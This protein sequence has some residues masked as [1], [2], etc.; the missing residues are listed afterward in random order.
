MR[1]C[2]SLVDFDEWRA[3]AGAVA[4][5]PTMGFL[6]EGHLALV[7]RARETGAPVVAS[8][9]VNPLQFGPEE[10]FEVYPRDEAQDAKLLE[11]EGCDVLLLPT[12]ED[13]YPRGF[14]TRVSVGGALTERLCGATRPGHF[15][16][17]ATVV[18]RLFRIVRPR[19]AVFGAKD[20]Q[21]LL[22]VRRL[23]DDLRL[24]VEVIGH[25]IVREADGLALSSRNVH[26]SPSERDEALWIQRALMHAATLV[27]EGETRVS[28][29]EDA[30][31]GELAR[32]Q[33]VRPHYVNILGAD[34][35]EPLTCVDRPVVMA[36]AAFVGQARL[37]DNRVLCPP[38]W[39][40]RA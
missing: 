15:D 35:L 5:V 8:I 14:A 38:G 21:Q 36:I 7:R 22:V 33:G 25:E 19:W 27:D 39:G 32:A 16:G 3:D 23:V 30:L 6:H 13:F 31:R 26:L 9:F 11:G 40:D 12:V 24:D 20:Y 28:T 29:L 34:D 17:V 10:D 18:T 37:I 4:F 1:T 2:R